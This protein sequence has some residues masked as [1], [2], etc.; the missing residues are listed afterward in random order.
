MKPAGRAVGQ[1]QLTKQTEWYQAVQQLG[2]ASHASLSSFS[3]SASS[4]TLPFGATVHLK[5]RKKA[6]CARWRRTL[7]LITA[8]MEEQGASDSDAGAATMG[9]L[10]DRTGVRA[11]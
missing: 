3:V 1:P 7:A 10:S 11:A 2:V 5:A 8:L 4:S 9:E 6:L